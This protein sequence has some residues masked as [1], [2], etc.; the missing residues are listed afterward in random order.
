MA[1]IVPVEINFVGNCHGTLNFFKIRKSVCN[2]YVLYMYINYKSNIGNAFSKRER[3]L[4]LNIK[5]CLIIRANPESLSLS[6]EVTTIL[7]LL[8][9][10][11]LYGIILWLW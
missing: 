10:V 7:V 4:L 3:I 9:I 5:F 2:Y 1:F 8:H 11:N 6:P